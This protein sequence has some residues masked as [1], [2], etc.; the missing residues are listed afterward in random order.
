MVVNTESVDIL[1]FRPRPFSPFGKQSIPAP[2]RE[3]MSPVPERFPD[4]ALTP[5]GATATN[6][7]AP[8]CPGPRPETV[9]AVRKAARALLAARAAAVGVDPAAGSRPSRVSASASA[10]RGTMVAQSTLDQ[11]LRK[12]RQ[13]FDRFLRDTGAPGEDVQPQDL[14]IWL[15]SLKPTL[16]SSSWRLYRQSAIH[17]LEGFPGETDAALA[18]LDNDVIDRGLP[19]SGA[20]ATGKGATRKEKRLPISDFEKLTTY[21]AK[22]NRSKLAPVVV[23]WLRAGVLTGLRPTEWRATDLV[24]QTYLG[25]P[26]GRRAWLYVLN[27]KATNGRGT[28]VVRTLDISAFTDRDLDCVRRMSDRG[29]TWLEAGNYVE[30]QAACSAV[31]HGATTRIWPQRRYAYTLYSCRHQAVANWKLL[32]KPEEVAALVG[33]GV[34]ATAAEHYGKRRS[35]WATEHIPAP[36]RPVEEELRRVEATMRLYAD[37]FRIEVRS[38]LRKEA[39]IPAYSVG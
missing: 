9:E 21:L 30:N 3:A 19:G 32:L 6:D 36:P 22:F 14:V 26:R 16:K 38:G 15:L 18:L 17:F 24:V 31:M 7:G 10:R 1:G 27:A 33:H 39:D 2:A 35:G 28:G 23:D 12:G 5:F 20:P 25:S 4:P 34:T 13:L 11:Y 8:S 29:R 37:R